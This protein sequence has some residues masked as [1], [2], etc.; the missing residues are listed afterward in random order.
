VARPGLPVAHPF[1]ILFSPT[2][3][4]LPCVNRRT[5]ILT[6]PSPRRRP[7]PHT[8]MRL[9]HPYPSLS[10]YRSPV[11]FNTIDSG[12]TLPIQCIHQLR[13]YVIYD[14]TFSMT[15]PISILVH[16]DTSVVILALPPSFVYPPSRMSRGMGIKQIPEGY[17][18]LEQLHTG[19][20][21]GDPPSRLY[22]AKNVSA[23]II[24]AGT[25]F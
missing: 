13:P 6:H 15:T 24:I 23:G 12:N 16:T 9:V 8:N 4:N 3:L 7:R 19:E 20:P 11:I 5:H 22:A 2:A 25:H 18:Q 21:K 10:Q 14:P 17:Q 1:L